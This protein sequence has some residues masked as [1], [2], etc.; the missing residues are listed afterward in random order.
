MSKQVSG[1][2][3]TDAVDEFVAPTDA[4]VRAETERMAAA[5][6]Q[7]LSPRIEHPDARSAD[8]IPGA[9]SRPSADATTFLG[10]GLAPVQPLPAHDFHYCGPEKRIALDRAFP[11]QPVVKHG[12]KDGDPIENLFTT[13]SLVGEEYIQ[14]GVQAGALLDWQQSSALAQL[15]ALSGPT[16]A[17]PAYNVAHARVWGSSGPLARLRGT[18]AIVRVTW[19]LPAY[20]TPWYLFAEPGG[21]VGAYG[22][23]KVTV[24]G[25]SEGVVS[26]EH[27]FLNAFG[28]GQL[29]WGIGLKG[30]P[31]ALTLDAGAL[32]SGASISVLAEVYAFAFWSN[33]GGLAYAGVDFGG[34]GNLDIYNQPYPGTAHGN[35]AIDRLAVSATVAQCRTIRLT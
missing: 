16:G 34:L 8:S 7:Q 27:S 28:T 14:L 29:T 19:H 24:N 1:V 17:D 6:K 30:G 2:V 22:V 5:F 15:P 10:P 9:I 35:K 26:R 12:T 18:R 21:L 31:H 23:L 20:G 13:F 32:S 11:I 4:E 25:G 3:S 33:N